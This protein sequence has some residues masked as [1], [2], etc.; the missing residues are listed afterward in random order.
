[1]GPSKKSTVLVELVC[2]T[3]KP[4]PWVVGHQPISV[5][6]GQVHVYL[7]NNGFNFDGANFPTRTDHAVGIGSQGVACGDLKSDAIATLDPVT[8]SPLFCGADVVTTGWGVDTVQTSFGFD[9]SPAAAGFASQQIDAT[10]RV[11]GQVRL[12]D[13]NGDLLLDRIMVLEGDDAIEVCLSL[14]DGALADPIGSG[15]SGTLGIP[16]IG[17]GSLAIPGSTATV[18]L[19]NARPNSAV[20]LGAS[21][22]L[23]PGF[24][25]TSNCVIYLG[26]PVLTFS[27]ASNALG[28]SSFSFVVPPGPLYEGLELFFQWVVYDDLGDYLGQ[29]ALSDALRLR[30]GQ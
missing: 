21:A 26:G 16:Q 8:G 4:M 3:R 10:G 17:A 1:M 24:I 2:D 29:L 15:C 11:P 19:T 13:L 22:S 14:Y 12:A 25:G 18:T 23:A 30:I 7:Q 28:Q 6:P 5:G 20:V 9:C 27:Q